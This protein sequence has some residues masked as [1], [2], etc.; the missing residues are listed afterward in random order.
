MS[1]ELA[2]T[3]KFL[4][5]AAG[6]EDERW[7]YSEVYWP[8]RAFSSAVFVAYPLRRFYGLG[9][10]EIIGSGTIRVLSAYSSLIQAYD[11]YSDTAT[12]LPSLTEI[13][14]NLVLDQMAQEVIRQVDGTGLDRGQKRDL[15]RM[16]N[17]SRY[18]LYQIEQQY[19]GR[20][21]SSSEAFE[22][23]KATGGTLLSSCVAIFNRCLSIGVEGASG[24]Q[25][26]FW[27]GANIQLLDDTVDVGS[28]I[29]A[30]RQ[31]PVISLLKEKGEYRGVVDY[32]SNGR[33]YSFG[34]LRNLAPQ[35][36]SLVEQ[37]RRE[38]LDQVPPLFTLD[39]YQEIC[40]PSL[41]PI[42]FRL[43]SA[44]SRRGS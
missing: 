27:Y 20:Q 7:F 16:V 32:T 13:K 15:I 37:K 9:Q 25:S 21:L 6:M 24:E 28:D 10:P 3:F 1:I 31:T 8:E 17:R 2:K 12:I 33:R 36:V 41:T 40:D 19:S 42:I 23:K 38:Y 44:A 5:H 30:G 29:L 39:G 26:A 14:E 34:A 4:R 35:T 22:W 43:Y 18:T 11:R